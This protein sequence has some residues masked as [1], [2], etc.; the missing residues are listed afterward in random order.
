MYA[1][2]IAGRSEELLCLTGI[3]GKEVVKGT[4]SCH[5]DVCLL[6][7][8]SQWFQEKPPTVAQG[9]KSVF[10]TVLIVNAQRKANKPLLQCLYAFKDLKAG[11]LHFGAVFN[12]INRLNALTSENE[13]QAS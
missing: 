5:H 8:F 10:N 1:V 6:G 7:L 3:R 9:P 2:C 4:Y 12:L 11:N 13:M